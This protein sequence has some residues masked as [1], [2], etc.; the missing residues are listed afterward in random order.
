MQS[1][2][3]LEPCCVILIAVQSGVRATAM[4]DAGALL[5]AQAPESC[6]D[7]AAVTA[8]VARGAVS[9]EPGDLAQALVDRWP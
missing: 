1:R 2:T 3:V 4:A 5:L 7:G 9:A 8:L 6:Y